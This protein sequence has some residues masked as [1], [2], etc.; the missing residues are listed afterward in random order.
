[1]ISIFLNI[2]PKTGSWGGGIVSQNFTQ[3]YHEGDEPSS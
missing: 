2:G 1:M 3:S